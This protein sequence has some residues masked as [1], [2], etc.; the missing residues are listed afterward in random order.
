MNEKIISDINKEISSK[1]FESDLKKVQEIDSN[2]YKEKITIEE[3][4]KYLDEYKSAEN[5][6]IGNVMIL[7]AGNPEVVFKSCLE[8]LNTKLDA[9]I[10][11]QDFCLAQNT[12]IV[13]MINKVI[14][15]NNLKI[16]LELKNL[17]S[18]K[19]IIELS[20]NIHKV[21]CIGD[22]NLYNRLEDKV[23][24]IELNSFGIFEIYSDSEEYEEL[25][26]TF[27]D[28]CYQN[29]FEAE[30]YSDLE[31]ED[32]LRIINKN[33]Y[34]FASVLFSKDKEK[35]EKFKTIDSKYIVINKNPF[36][37]IDFKLKF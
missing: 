37:E 31:F 16:K 26:K 19:Q 34:K 2:H 7:L 17:I 5:V 36:K 18:D 6:N 30:D 24:N 33:G 10:G 4:K 35:Q 29:E 12:L 23:K 25:E 3:M 13:E 8:I 22:S 1:S 27:F 20:K 32:A 21:I 15:N 11:I 9:I 28:Y 14:K